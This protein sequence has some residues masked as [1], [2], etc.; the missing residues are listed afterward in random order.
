MIIE[1]IAA[2]EEEDDTDGDEKYK[3][4]DDDDDDDD[5]KNEDDMEDK[6]GEDFRGFSVFPLLFKAIAAVDL[7]QADDHRSE[8]GSWAPTKD[9][10]GDALDVNGR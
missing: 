3:S 1:E 10:R 9:I 4:E 8:T 6:E 7:G 2:A 5:D